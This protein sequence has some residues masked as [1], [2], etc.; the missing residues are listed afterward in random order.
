M[1]W[2]K[3]KRNEKPRIHTGAHYSDR[4]HPGY[5]LCG[6]TE[7]DDSQTAGA[8]VKCQTCVRRLRELRRKRK[9]VVAR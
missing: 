6:L 1:T 9:A 4:R 8:A 5:S 3:W 2:L 7:G